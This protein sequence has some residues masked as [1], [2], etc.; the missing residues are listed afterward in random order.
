MWSKRAC[1]AGV[2]VCSQC[3]ASYRQDRE[4]PIMVQATLVENNIMNEF[5][6]SIE[7]IN[8]RFVIHFKEKQNEKSKKLN[9]IGRL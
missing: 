6:E 5:S 9:S 1:S 2:D 8:K 4:E 3:L 7:R